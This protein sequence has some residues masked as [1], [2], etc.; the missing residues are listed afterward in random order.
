MAMYHCHISNIGRS[1]GRSA[2][3]AAAYRSG[4]KLTDEEQGITHDY[5][6]KRNIVYSEIILPQNAPKEYQDRATLWNAVQEKETA[7][8]A[9]LAREW[10]VSIPNELT[11]DQAKE[12]VHGFAQTLAGEGMCVD[13][14]IHWNEGNHHA[15][16]M[17]T[18]RAINEKGQWAGKSRK[19]Y[20]LDEQGNKI[21]IIDKKTGEQKVDKD[22]RKQWKNHKEDY[23]DWNKSEKVDEW[24]ARWADHANKA[25]E[26]AQIEERVDHRSYKDQGIDQQPTVHEGH[27]AREIEARGGVSE[28]MQLNRDIREYNRLTVEE[29]ATNID[30]MKA[31]LALAKEAESE[32]EAENERAGARQ[33]FLERSGGED[34]RPEERIQERSGQ[35]EST[36]QRQSERSGS[37][38][39]T[40]QRQSERSRSVEEAVRTEQ[41]EGQGVT[42]DSGELAVAYS[43]ANGRFRAEREGAWRTRENVER[44]GGTVAEASGTVRTE[45]ERLGGFRRAVERIR[46][47]T[48]GNGQRNADLGRT[49]EQ[50]RS[51]ESQFRK[52]GES[53]NR[54]QSAFRQVGS[55]ATRLTEQVRQLEQRIKEKAEQARQ[56]FQRRPQD[57]GEQKIMATMNKFNRI[58]EETQ[59]VRNT[60]QTRENAHKSVSMSKC[61]KIYLKNE[62]ARTEASSPLKTEMGKN[63]KDQNNA[64]SKFERISR[65]QSAGREEPKK[66]EEE[67]TETVHRRRGIHH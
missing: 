65:E 21:P 12:L 59:Q 56:A 19:V 67:H 57:E 29:K 7:K 17:G 63:G 11:L 45:G 43:K 36:V 31:I 33:G 62:K 16:I 6:R 48:H 18:T 38:E 37:V 53:G 2:V 44:S 27:A 14:S 41:R 22:N 61:D 34:A 54:L 9:R 51:A 1:S 32:K 5:T 39:S 3:A 15:H 13:Y 24:R 10:E 4:E 60:S 28:T 8:D 46:A 35:V 47:F 26:E 52:E 50:I 20:D 40:V 66:Q 25:L 23:T 64:M 42:V 30:R 55:L 58:S 49:E